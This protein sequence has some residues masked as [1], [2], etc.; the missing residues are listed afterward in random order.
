MAMTEGERSPLHA[1]ALQIGYHLITPRIVAYLVV[2]VVVG[3]VGAELCYIVVGHRSAG[4][5]VAKIF[6]TFTDRSTAAARFGV[7]IND[8]RAWS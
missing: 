5:M 2:V 3:V 1:L 7:I 8:Y 6:C 4:Q